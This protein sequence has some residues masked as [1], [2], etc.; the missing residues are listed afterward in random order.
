MYVPKESR[1]AKKCVMYSYVKTNRLQLERSRRYS[2][3]LC[4]QLGVSEN[5]EIP[6]KS[7]SAGSCLIYESNGKR[8][9]LEHLGRSYDEFPTEFATINIDGKL[10]AV[11]LYELHIRT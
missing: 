5:I 7:T 6:R 1:L 3:E 4:T 8:K 10:C 11:F 2:D 9:G